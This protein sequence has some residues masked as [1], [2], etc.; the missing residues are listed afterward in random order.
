[1]K[2]YDKQYQMNKTRTEQMNKTCFESADPSHPGV[3]HRRFLIQ[4]Y[5]ILYASASASS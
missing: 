2:I 1:M 5:G 3:L 4:L